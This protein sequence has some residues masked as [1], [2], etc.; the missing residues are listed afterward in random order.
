MKEETLL[1]EVKLL[2]KLKLSNRDRL[3]LTHIVRKDHKNTPSKITAELNDHLKGPVSSKNGKR[4]LHK[5]GFH[6]RAAI[7][8]PY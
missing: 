8:K 7:R 2:K 4:E 5:A 6:R 1:T 3:T